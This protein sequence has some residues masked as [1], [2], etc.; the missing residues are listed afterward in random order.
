MAEG[1]TVLLYLN[2]DHPEEY[3]GDPSGDYVYVII[4]I[5][6]IPVGIGG[7]GYTIN[8]KKNAV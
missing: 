6:I 7:L 5:G 2:P 3:M 4:G 8:K 1:D